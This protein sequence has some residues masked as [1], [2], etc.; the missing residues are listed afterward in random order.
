MEVIKKIEAKSEF[1]AW[2]KR[3]GFVDY[4]EYMKLFGDNKAK[5]RTAVMRFLESNKQ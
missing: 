4:A 2:L 1:R 3:I 5:R